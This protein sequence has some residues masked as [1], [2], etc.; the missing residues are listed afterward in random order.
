MC[1]GCQHVLSHFPSFSKDDLDVA[2]SAAFSSKEAAAQ[3]DTRAKA[4]RARSE[5]QEA[6]S[7]VR[8]LT[9]EKGE[10]LLQEVADDARQ[11]AVEVEKQA[12]GRAQRKHS[13]PG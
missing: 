3:A 11:L 10:N 13:L 9:A 12:G 1:M 7:E 8:G 4:E 6:N 5:L 2:L